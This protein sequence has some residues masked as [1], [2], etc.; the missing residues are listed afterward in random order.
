MLQDVCY[1]Q[2]GKRVQTA[3]NCRDG[4]LAF[5]SSLPTLLRFSAVVSNRA[6]SPERNV[7]GAD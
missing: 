7:L 2:G 6:C 4:Y 1:D 5:L 3:W